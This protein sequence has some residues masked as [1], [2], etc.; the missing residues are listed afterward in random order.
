MNREPSQIKT[1]V[2][3]VGLSGAGKSTASRAL[4]DFGFY[5]VDNLPVGLFDE[6]LS[7]ATKPSSRFN[8][9]CLLLDIAS[10][11]ECS[12]FLRRL[13]ELSSEN[14]EVRVIFLDSDTD[15]IVRRYSETRRPHP[16]FESGTDT[17][18]AATIQRE[19]NRLQ[20]IKEI[21]NLVIDT[22]AVTVHDLK[23]LLRDA[24]DTF[25]VQA[26]HQLRINFLSFGFKYGVPRDCDLV[27]DVRFL[28]NPYFVEE[29]RPLTGEDR[30]VSEYV[31]AHDAAQEFLEHY[32]EL[33]DFLLPQYS[34]EGKS[35]LNIGI[36]CTGGKHR[37]VALAIELADRI[38]ASHGEY[39]VSSAH[40][41]AS[42]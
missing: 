1:L 25:H 35:Y 30:A 27:V 33:L 32:C 12:D 21:A 42:H 38:R 40:R 4:S 6:F 24:V 9:T 3:V 39:L 8:Q 36:G 17:T 18:L 14:I 29:L 10:Q 22:S 31:L 2:L 15:S 16:A 41:D 11:E 37:S 34:Y 26:A 7:F 23:R 5:S 19:R 28:P 13:K 20:P